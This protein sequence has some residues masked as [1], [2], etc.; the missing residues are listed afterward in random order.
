MIFQIKTFAAFLS[1]MAPV[2]VIVL[3]PTPI[4][5]GQSD[6][7]QQMQPNEQLPKREKD[8]TAE[9][10]EMEGESPVAV[11]RA[12][13][14]EL[15]K[16]ITFSETAPSVDAHHQANASFV[17][18]LLDLYKQESKDPA[19]V[20]PMAV[21]VFNK[22]AEYQ[23][24]ATNRDT[25]A[26][27][28]FTQEI[29]RIGRQCFRKG[30][31]DPMLMSIVSMAASKAKK[32]AGANKFGKIA[33]DGFPK[34]TYPK[35]LHW[36]AWNALAQAEDLLKVPGKLEATRKKFV[37]AS[38]SFLSYVETLS[39]IVTKP[40]ARRL[41]YLWILWGLQ[42]CDS[43]VFDLQSLTQAY[44]TREDTD[45]WISEMLN[46][47]LNRDLA[48][49][50]RGSGYASKVTKEGWEKFHEYRPISAKHF[51]KA[52]RIDPAIPEPA[53]AMLSV[54]R[55]G[56]SDESEWYWF[57]RSIDIEIDNSAAYSHMLWA[58]MPRWGGS[59]DEMLRL[60]LQ[61]LESN[62][63]DTTIPYQYVE[64]VNNVRRDFGYESDEAIEFVQRPDVYE[65]L[66]RAFE[67]LTDHPSQKIAEGLSS[68]QTNY[69]TEWLGFARIADHFEDTIK[70]IDRLQD[71]LTEDVIRQFNIRFR[72]D[73]SRAAAY[74]EFGDEM[75]AARELTLTPRI[76][77]DRKKKMLAAYQN[78]L[79]KCQND[80]SR[81]YLQSWV[82]ISQNEIDFLEG[83]WVHLK[84][85]SDFGQWS[86]GTGDW[87]VISPDEIEGVARGSDK[88]SLYSMANFPGPI[89]IRLEFEP[90]KVVSYY[91]R[92]ALLVDQSNDRRSTRSYWVDRDRKLAG[93]RGQGSFNGY[94]EPQYEVQRR[95]HLRLWGPSRVEFLTNGIRTLVTEDPDL[96]MTASEIGIGVCKGFHDS[97]TV[98]VKHLRVRKLTDD[99]IPIRSDF[100]SSD[101]YLK[102]S[103]GYYDEMIKRHPDHHQHFNDRA[104]LHLSAGDFEAAINDYQTVLKLSP[105]RVDA[106]DYLANLLCSTGQSERGLK[107]YEIA[108]RDSQ[109]SP[110][111]QSLIRANYAYSLAT[112]PDGAG[113]DVAKSL[114][115][116]KL[117]T[118]PYRGKR[119]RLVWASL[120]YAQ[121]ANGQ[122]EQAEKSIET[123]KTKHP[124]Y[125]YEPAIIAKIEKA[126]EKRE[127]INSGDN[128][129]QE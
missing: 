52:L 42:N 107:Q 116:A 90:V 56:Y 8:V 2:A 24:S 12:L 109:R 68:S 119:F 124:Y 72:Y 96:E 82:E 73:R 125:F 99:P 49:H 108:V 31:R 32:P 103:I 63:F 55:D 87:T 5:Y 117:A 40:R 13:H 27:L 129:E 41:L 7:P 97:G 23:W 93:W 21:T 91:F 61:C 95:L 30:S 53:I 126:I 39:P 94:K 71:N 25:S 59:Q 102:A 64:A 37:L 83:K 11:L 47:T 33:R 28:K 101:E 70:L 34:S 123:A 106:R 112:A 105:L 85:D 75:L 111:R 10:D 16:E 114:E 60:G 50:Y 78:L 58:L 118:V 69:L 38:P 86:G 18:H 22:Y 66:S 15:T 19:V 46:A 67:G 104:F 45:P 51:R 36:L 81:F 79:S 89:E 88:L 4:V 122:W 44:Q 76:E 14:A 54:A 62:R 20:R 128:A 98:R 6:L 77:L 43:S 110:F 127:L 17:K 80:D 9:R 1:F 92:L 113:R 115:Q 48:W 65:N 3:A 120:A 29:L 26:D 74:L 84:F 100:Q 35:A 121:A 57:Q